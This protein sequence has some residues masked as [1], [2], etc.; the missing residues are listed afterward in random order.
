MKSKKNKVSSEEASDL[1][2]GQIYLYNVKRRR[3]M[4]CFVLKSPLRAREMAGFLLRVLAGKPGSI[5]SIHMETHLP[6]T[7][8]AG[9]LIPP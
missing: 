4:M 8:A 6:V 1:I 7:P 2:W 3:R 5:L 9:H